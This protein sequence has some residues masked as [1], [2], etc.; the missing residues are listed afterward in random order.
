MSDE[1]HNPDHESPATGHVRHTVL[2]QVLQIVREQAYEGRAD[3]T[4]MAAETNLIA[5]GA[6]SLDRMEIL[7]QVEEEFDLS[8]MDD[9]WDLCHTP[10][11]IAELVERLLAARKEQE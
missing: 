4:A 5:A 2:D 1:Q 9:D 8:I 10:R 6:D 7:M 3:G 11:E